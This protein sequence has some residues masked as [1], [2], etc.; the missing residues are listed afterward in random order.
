VYKFVN[1]STK[2]IVF[3]ADCIG[4]CVWVLLHAG[5]PASLFKKRPMPGHPKRIL[6]IRADY[7]GD[8]LLTTHTLPSIRKRFPASKICYLVSSKSKTII[9]N[10]PYIDTIVTYD[11]PWFFKKGLKQ[12]MPEYI[13]LL[14]WIR[15]Q[16]FDVAVDFRGDVR[17]ILLLMVFGGV[18]YRVSFGASGGSYLLS[19]SVA[20]PP[21]RHE[22]AYHTRIAEALDGLRIPAGALP[23]TVVNSTERAVADDFFKRHGLD[24][25]RLAVAI[26]PGA[27]KIV[28][29]WPAERY[30]AVGR[31][32]IEKYGAGVILVGA[33]DEKRLLD[34]VNELMG[35]GAAVA[36]G[37]I[38][39][40]NQL[41]AL[42]SRCYLYVG[43][44][45]G[46]SHVA[47]AN[48]VATVLIFGPESQ[49]QWRPLGNQYAIIKKD[50]PCSPCTQK[51]CPILDANCI[52]SVSVEDVIAGI[53]GILS[54]ASRQK[55]VVKVN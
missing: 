12:A 23:E 44:S 32:L 48:G 16:Q 20:Y 6:L 13:R 33:P 38:N 51:Q 2:I 8:V 9:V 4:F 27:R 15:R 53:D 42:L 3:I 25:H 17:N 5:M 1:N 34:H 36:A 49:T 40:L 45:S 37:E 14:A 29:L 26:H 54:D 39:S 10:N 41:S 22:A 35:G 24:C 46:P 43:V 30:A 52:R 19:R 50:F 47:A 11:P 31:Y 28:R 7:I 21:G 18:P 55:S